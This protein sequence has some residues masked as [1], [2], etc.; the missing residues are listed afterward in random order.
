M[1]RIFPGEYLFILGGTDPV[2]TKKRTP[3]PEKKL[4]KSPTARRGRQSPS[5]Q[6]ASLGEQFPGPKIHLLWTHGESSPERAWR[7]IRAKCKVPD[8]VQLASPHLG[9]LSAQGFATSR[10]SP[11]VPWTE[12]GTACCQAW[13]SLHVLSGP[14]T[15]LLHWGPAEPIVHAAPRGPGRIIPARARPRA[16]QRG[17]S[18]CAARVLLRHRDS[19]APSSSMSKPPALSRLRSFFCQGRAAAAGLASLFSFCSSKCMRAVVSVS[20]SMSSSCCS[21][22]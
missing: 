16:P 5:F 7:P 8:P 13:L 22:R 19:S 9:S 12:N 11:C 10:T 15:S 1:Y 4:T 2:S 21:F 14:H 6:K 20:I 3:A 18:A 17:R